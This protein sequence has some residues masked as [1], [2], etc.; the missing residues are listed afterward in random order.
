[1]K[2]RLLD[3]FPA[4]LFRPMTKT[5]EYGFRRM[6][7]RLKK[8]LNNPLTFEEMI[9]DGVMSINIRKVLSFNEKIGASTYQWDGTVNYDQTPHEQSGYP[10][11]LSRKY[12]SLLKDLLNDQEKFD[13]LAL[14]GPYEFRFGSIEDEKVE[15][16]I[17]LGN[18]VPD[19]GPNYDWSIRE[20]GTIW[21]H[22]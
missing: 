6:M 11:E 3:E 5:E 10:M 2:K 9:F 20:D 21:F 7:K 13:L 8:K 15:P 1:M 12:L 22:S 18:H 4:Y 17:L 16:G 14:I 19:C